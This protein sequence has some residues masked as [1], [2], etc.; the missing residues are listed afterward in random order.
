MSPRSVAKV[1]NLSNKQVTNRFSMMGKLAIVGG[2]EE[3]QGYFERLAG[4]PVFRSNAQLPTPDA[5]GRSLASSQGEGGVGPWFY[6]IAAEW[7][8]NHGRGAP[9]PWEEGARAALR[10][11]SHKQSRGGERGLRRSLQALNV[12][13][14]SETVPE[15]DTLPV[16][17]ETTPAPPASGTVARSRSTMARSS[18]SAISSRVARARRR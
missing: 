17:T 4:R 14:C 15:A 6:Q 18:G 5:E 11:C 13:R 3:T 10:H 12:G 2:D 9:A 8:G 1:R 7:L 16:V